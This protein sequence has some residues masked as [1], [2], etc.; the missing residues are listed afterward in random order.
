MTVA[1]NY[2]DCF[3]LVLADFLI[4]SKSNDNY[5]TN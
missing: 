2:E 3:G 5:S 4:A 1:I